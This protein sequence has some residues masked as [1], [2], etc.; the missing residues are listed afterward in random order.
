VRISFIRPNIGRLEDG[1]FLERGKM[2][3]LE[4]GVVAALAPPD[5]DCVLYDDRV[6]DIPYDEPTDL[7]AIT[8]EVHTARRAYEIAAEYRKRDVPVIMGGFHATLAPQECLLHADS[9]YVGDAEALWAQAVEDA[10]RGRLRR[11]YKAPF[12]LPQLGRVR[13]RRD[14]FRGKGY[15]PIN[16]VQFTRGCRYACNFCAISAFFGRKQRARPVQ[17]VIEEVEALDGR[18]IF[19]VD[20]NFLANPEAVKPFLRALI[21]LKVRWVSQASI[22]MANDPELMDLVE[23]SGCIGTVTGFESLDPRNLRAMKKAPNLLGRTWDSYQRQVESLRAHHLQ[24]WAAFTLGHDYDTQESIREI[25]DF[26]V[27]NK[28]CLAGFNILLPYPS[29]PLYNR[30]HSENR[31]LWDGQW[32]LHPD[33][34]FNHAAFVPKNMTPEELTQVCWDCRVK[35][36]SAASILRRMLD[37]KTNLS[38]PVRLAFYLY[39]NLLYAREIRNK[40]GMRFGWHKD[41]VGPHERSLTAAAGD[42]VL[43]DA[44]PAV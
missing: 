8:V 21:P 16:L 1:P 35:W 40:Q 39:Y 33:Y 27:E 17:D 44:T 5:V 29:T 34:R 19:F 12:G 38:S 36:N 42:A 11:L 24:T 26:A 18:T 37:P 3:P 2:E 6:E 22:D 25:H 9:V 14:L 32:W 13:P 28:F 20:D 31:L 23:A 7:A 43:G 30:L 4:L 15:L 41:I 10:R